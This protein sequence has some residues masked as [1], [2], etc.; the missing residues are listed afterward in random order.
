[1]RARRRQGA[2]SVVACAIARARAT[3]AIA[4][5]VT[6]AW[7]PRVLAY[8]VATIHPG[9][10]GAPEDSI[11][12][13]FPVRRAP[14]LL[15]LRAVA[16]LATMAASAEPA[17]LLRRDADPLVSGSGGAGGAGAGAQ[18]AADRQADA[19]VVS[20]AKSFAVEMGRNRDASL[21]QTLDLTLRGKVAGDL[22]VAATLSDQRLPFEPDG[23][24]RELEDLDRVSISLRA[25]QGGATLGDF[26]LEGIP[27]EFA[28]VTR[29][30]QG[31]QGEAR[32]G[33]L[34]WD[35]AA[36]SPKGERRSLE[37]RGEDGKQGPYA[38]LG[39]G[40]DADLG[41]I[42]AG[43]ETVWLD[44]VKLRRG[45]DLDYV[46]DYGAASLTFTVRH[47]V[48]AESRIAVDFEGANGR[49]RRTFYAATTRREWG[50][51]GWYASY[52]REGD[53]AKSPLGAALTPEDR[54]ALGA[55]GDSATTTLPSGVRYVGAGAGTYVWDGS[56]PSRAHWLWLG[57]ARGDYD[58]EFTPVGAGR[59]SYADTLAADGTR[60][61]RFMGPTLGTF[62][63]GRALAV[64]RENALMDLGG[65]TRIGALALE[66]EAAR[67]GFDRNS[68]SSRDDGDNT[69]GAGRLAARLDPRAIRIFGARL[70]SVSAAASLRAR[71][72]RFSSLD[73]TEGAFE[74]ER[75]NQAPSTAGERRQEFSLAY[76]PVAVLGLR[77]E[78][79]LRSLSGGSR[80]TRRA[81]VLE[82]RSFLPGAVRWDEARNRGPLGDGRRSKWSLD[83]AR[84]TGPLQPRLSVALERIAGQEGDSA[85][86][87]SS[88]L[89]SAG[90]GW[91]PGAALR[92]RSSVGWR[93]D[94]ARIL[95]VSNGTEARTWEGG[96]AAR[97][98][99]AF[100]ADASFSRR[101][102]A[103]S[104]G[105]SAADLAQLVLTGG[106]AGGPVSS[107]LRYDVT[108]LREP[109]V[110]RS[111]TAVGTG[112]GSYD[113]YGNAQQGG[114]YELVS[115]AGEPATRSR[116]TVQLRLDAYPGRSAR[117]A[118]SALR[119][120]G[121]STFFRLETLSSLPLGRL[122]T[123]AR[124]SDYL[125][126]GSTLR[127]TLAARQSFEVVPQG[128]RFEAR[129]E[130]GTSRDVSG[131]LTG[132]ESRGRGM[133]GRLR[134][135][136]VLPLGLRATATADLSRNEQ[137]VA[138]DDGAGVY[139]SLVRGRG[140]ELELARAIGAV[141]T[142][143]LVSRHRRD[144]DMT[145]GGYQD[146]WSVG[147]SARC[148]G[149]R[150]RLDGSAS[151]GRL[152]QHGTY[153]PAG[154]YLIA[155][156]GPRVDVDLLGEYRAGDRISLS[157]G[158][159]GSQVEG[160]PTTYTGRFEL[161][162]SF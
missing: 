107:E 147:P 45:A 114:G 85:D 108:Q 75:W 22:E 123:I 139:A 119:P 73:R 27:G 96:V 133:D 59:G 80:A 98:G 49:Y 61:Y 111:L 130:V 69:G 20:G 121:A 142:A 64:P 19:L 136:R 150:L 62:E 12:L 117:S 118:K 134:V 138:R 26:R 157:L 54:T 71:D 94:E 37:F 52:L 17:T 11:V 126:S 21:H 66:G 87:R 112:A 140:Y 105:P 4:V 23:S 160:R 124:P 35:V 33:G 146:A 132:L 81:A 41:G 159:N 10:D 127:G 129:L 14:S 149:A 148:A 89:W 131:E 106:R 128:S 51:G 63:P 16:P 32:V 47:P 72:A 60:F 57:P 2:R 110:T 39:R 113:A 104:K 120:F 58:V 6:C 18:D 92:L 77:G 143:S 95:G 125:A 162:S 7:A 13:E 97:A 161:R 46:M 25:P 115:G 42:V 74:N 44:G 145:R 24:T 8:P 99:D 141:W 153:A 1:M 156:L 65:A 155:P 102:V 137:A 67:S 43:S 5:A 109:A 88:R 122:E 76:D 90:L 50:R 158:W 30:L 86:A 34:R 29:A 56:D 31:V 135:K 28:S 83:F 78:A 91:S 93:R 68:L 100:L 55:M 82:V 70:G 53:D 79:G 144:V 36:A 38:L 152:D 151:Y 15:S 116:A 40:A 103:G 154:R 3:L 9:G 101:R 84:V 48:T